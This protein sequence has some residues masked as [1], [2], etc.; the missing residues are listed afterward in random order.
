M[1]GVSGSSRMFTA[2]ELI[3]ALRR[4]TVRSLRPERPVGEF[5]PGWRAWFA[6]LREQAGRIRGATADAIIAIFLARE[7]RPAPRAVAALSDWEAFTTLWRQEWAPSGADSRAQR[8]AA[9]VITLV[10]ELVLAI[11]LIWLAYARWGGA[12]PPPGEEVIQVEFIGVGTPQELGGGAPSGPAPEP[13]AAAPSAAPR[14]AQAPAHP[15]P[16][17]APARATESAPPPPAVATREPEPAPEPVPAPP[18]AAPEPAPEEAAPALQPLQVTEV[19]VPD[20]RFTVQVP[21]L[22]TEVESIQRFER[23][24]TTR[25]AVEAPVAA[26]RVPE[27]ETAPQALPAPAPPLPGTSL[28]SIQARP[29]QVRVPGLEAEVESLPGAV[30]PVAGAARTPVATPSATVT[31]PGLATGVASLPMPGGAPAGSGSSSDAGAVPQAQGGGT[32]AGAPAGE[33]GGRSA[34]AGGVQGAL[35]GEGAGPKP[36]EAAGA[37]TSPQAGTDWGIGDRNQ[38]GG[39][40]GGGSGLFDESGRVKLPPG[41]V[42]DGMLGPDGVLETEIADLDRAGTWLKRPPIDYTPT[43]F[44]EYWLPGGTL[45]EEWVRRGIR[46]VAIRIPGTSKKI[47]CVVSLLQLGGGC[48]IDDP[49]M[50]DQEA[51]ARPAPEIPWKPELQENQEALDQPAG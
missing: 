46:E 49:N 25:R 40:A 4:R 38:A 51:T 34:Q 26:V 48:G 47:H 14:S 31:V 32:T 11:F 12:P 27:L 2:A 43:R 7:P 37:W 50:Q 41:T 13:A 23:P 24:T 35:A 9:M 6:S 10:V 18:A 21:E 33:A 44:D 39:Q 17:P 29:V 45:L 3:E 22:A 36:G 15:A 20:T 28:R 5:P 8:I 19:A 1:P 42:G 16:A 30:A